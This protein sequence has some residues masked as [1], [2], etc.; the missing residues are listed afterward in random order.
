MLS[1]VLG[2]M[3]IQARVGTLLLVA[4]VVLL[5]VG[6]AAQRWTWQAVPGEVV[7]ADLTGISSRRRVKASW[8]YTVSGQRYVESYW[9]TP[10]LGATHTS[11][12][13]MVAP[14]PLVLPALGP[15]TVYVSRLDPKYSAL[16]RGPSFVTW[17]VL[18]LGAL[19]F[20][21]DRALAAMAEDDDDPLQPRA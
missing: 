5:D 16:Q 19:L 15:T 9:G 12:A 4:L 10:F 8:A 14:V 7:K 2:F 17:G 21:A 13:V 3:P 11:N 20:G 18:L 6:A 1:H